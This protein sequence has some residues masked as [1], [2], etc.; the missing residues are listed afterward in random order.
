MRALIWSWCCFLEVSYT[1]IPL[2]RRGSNSVIWKYVL[3]RLLRSGCRRGLFECR[4]NQ[5]FDGVYVYIKVLFSRSAP[6]VSSHVTHI[7]DLSRQ[8]LSSSPVVPGRLDHPAVQIAVKVKT[9]LRILNNYNISQLYYSALRLII[10]KVLEYLS[11]Q[12]SVHYSK[13]FWILFEYSKIIL[14]PNNVEIFMCIALSERI[15]GNTCK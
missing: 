1:G 13:W 14:W 10:T 7:G 5:Q 8:A 2:S 3:S 4:N 11:I 9:L 15:F 12:Y 6:L